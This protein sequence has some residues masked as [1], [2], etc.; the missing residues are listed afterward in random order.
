MP[1]TELRSRKYQVI[2]FK[3]VGSCAPHTPSARRSLEIYVALRRRPRACGG[4]PPSISRL[5]QALARP[6]VAEILR[7]CGASLNP[8]NARSLIVGIK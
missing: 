4:L 2:F 8:N 3:S 7:G 5:R 6:R 1:D